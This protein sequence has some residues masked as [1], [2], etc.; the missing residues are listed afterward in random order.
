VFNFFIPAAAILGVYKS[1]LIRYSWT[2][3]TYLEFLDSAL[4]LVSKLLTQG[5]IAV[6]LKS[7]MLRSPSWKEWW[8]VVCISD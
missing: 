4:L 7:T 8:Y 3:W 1:Q 6:R 5:F 2:C